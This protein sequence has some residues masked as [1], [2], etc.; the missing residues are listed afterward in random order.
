MCIRDRF[1]WVKEDRDDGRAIYEVEFYAN[2]TEYDYEIEQSTGRI[3]S[4][5]H[6]IENYSPNTGANANSG[7]GAIISLDE[8]RTLVLARVPGATANDV[9]IQL[10]RD[11]GRQIYEGEIYYNQMEYEFEID[12]SSGN[13]IEW[14]AERWD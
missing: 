10:D 7:N 3:L 12:A 5:D 6:D 13:I 4:S 9:R 1:I 11:D 8:A 14:S 2:G